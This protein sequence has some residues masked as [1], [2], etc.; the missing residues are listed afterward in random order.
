MPAYP[1]GQKS[2]RPRLDPVVA[3]ARNMVA[4]LLG[5]SS[6]GRIRPAAEPPLVLV[7]CSGGP[8][9]LALAAVA[10][11]FVHRGE[12]RVGAVVVDHQLQPGS[13]EV[14][15]GAAAALRG[16][17]LDPVQI[18]TVD[19]AHDGDGPEASA[20]TAR[21][22]ALDEAARELGASEVLL[23]H[24][25]DDQAESVLLGLVRGSG[26]RSLAGI[27]QRRGIYLRPLLGLRREE[28]LEICDTL[29]LDPWH[30][31]TN[32]DPAFM[33]S[34]VRTVVLPFLAEQLG[35]GIAPS[36]Y[37]S[38]RI[39]AADADYL[40][41]LAGA[42]FARLAEQL[43]APAGDEDKNNDDGA[44]AWA[45]DATA[46]QRL[47]Q[48]LPQEVRLPEDA[49]RALAPALRQR[50]LAL[51]VV[52]LGGSQPSY[53]RLLAAQSLLE[54]RGSAGPVE[55]AGK[56]SVSR[57]PRSQGSPHEGSGYGKLVFRR[58]A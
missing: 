34:R 23:G 53:E 52:A 8:D 5:I 27:P 30:D 29:G 10:A 35:A 25:L 55:L 36:L 32:A 21:Y 6:T 3:K 41:E 20:R 37:R 9:S 42:E 48:E 14:A 33:R 16:L 56:V 18:R 15:A 38:A 17:G 22:G 31:P 2:P 1:A 54:R 12:V 51:A 11:F 40:D 57:I 13:A 4:A 19:V 24:T 43:P 45:A 58:N 28:T 26:T 49:L 44:P 47:L 50:V 46:P 39:L 7:A